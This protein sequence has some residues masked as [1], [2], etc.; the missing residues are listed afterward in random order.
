MKRLN[1][2]LRWETFNGGFYCENYHQFSLIYG[3]VGVGVCFHQPADGS[4]LTLCGVANSTEIIFFANS[5]VQFSLNQPTED[6]K[7]CLKSNALIG[8]E[9][10]VKLKSIR[11]FPR[12]FRPAQ[13]ESIMHILEMM[14]YFDPT[15]KWGLNERLCA[16]E[17]MKLVRNLKVCHDDVNGGR[18]ILI[19]RNNV[20]VGRDVCEWDKR[21]IIFYIL[22]ESSGINS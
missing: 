11:Y 13:Y 22:S 5:W 9:R 10:N 15:H 1:L 19:C 4:S 2:Y 12:S 16:L 17:K 8:R 18:G 7:K 21:I 3:A 14:L 6:E 20:I